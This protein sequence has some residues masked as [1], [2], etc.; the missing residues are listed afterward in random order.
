MHPLAFLRHLLLEL[1]A[2]LALSLLL[3]A[4]PRLGRAQGGGIAV[5][6]VAP[7]AAVT[8][9]DGAAADLS[10]Y[11]GKTPVVLEFWATWCPLCKQLEPAMS[12]ARHKYAGRVTFVSV[13]VPN[14]QSPQGQKAFAAKHGMTGVLVFDRDGQAVKAYATP[15]TS[16]VVAIDTAG[17]VVYTGVGGAQDIESAVALALSA[18]AMIRGSG[19]R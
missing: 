11:I 1:R 19:R 12:T 9:L 16:F 14:N 8:T 4:V 15:H 3:L 2:L 10:S 13:G 18:P 6:A 5:G 17:K 7:G